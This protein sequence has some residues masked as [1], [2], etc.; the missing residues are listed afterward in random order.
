LTFTCQSKSH[1]WSQPWFSFQLKT[2]SKENKSTD[3]IQLKNKSC[4]VFD[5]FFMPQPTGNLNEA[6]LLKQDSAELDKTPARVAK[7]R[8]RS[9]SRSRRSVCVCCPTDSAAASS[10]CSPTTTDERLH[11]TQVSL[12]TPRKTPRV[13][14]AEQSQP[15]SVVSV[16][17]ESDFVFGIQRK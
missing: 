14:R 3:E 2:Q 7:E 1:F 12:R 17:E 10:D 4:E 13:S 5:D 9:G 15:Q 16:T 8:R 11:E 6:F